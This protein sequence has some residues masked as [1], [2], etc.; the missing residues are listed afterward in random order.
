MGLAAVPAFIL[1]QG[2]QAGDMHAA[3]GAAHHGLGLFG[4]AR[5]LLWWAGKTSPEPEGGR[6]KGKPEQQTEQT[7]GALF[8]KVDGQFS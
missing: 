1:G 6:D 7:H 4:G 2:M 3:V 5:T 8:V